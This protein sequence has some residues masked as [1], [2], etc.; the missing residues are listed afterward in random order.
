MPRDRFILVDRTPGHE[1]QA[2]G[3]DRR[4]EVR[5]GDDAD[6][7]TAVPKRDPQTDVRVHVTGA[8]DGDEQDPHAYRDRGLAGGLG[9][10]ACKV[11]VDEALETGLVGEAHDLLDNLAVLEDQ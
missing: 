5:V 10:C 2:R 7:V 1:P 6:V 4:G 9:R 11:F 3:G 8:A